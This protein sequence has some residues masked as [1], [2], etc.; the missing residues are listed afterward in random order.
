VNTIFS[1]KEINGVVG[2]RDRLRCSSDKLV[3]KEMM[4]KFPSTLALLLPVAKERSI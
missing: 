3:D 2:S 4:A 1:S